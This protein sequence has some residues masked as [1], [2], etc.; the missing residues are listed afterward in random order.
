MQLS[1]I[2]SGQGTKHHV[3]KGPN[4]GGRVIQALRHMK[5]PDVQT[6]SHITRFDLDFVKRFDVVGHEGNRHHKNLLAFL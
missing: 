4:E 2:F 6:L 3:G 5:T 1:G